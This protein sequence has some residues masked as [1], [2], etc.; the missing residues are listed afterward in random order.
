MRPMKRIPDTLR[1]SA[2]LTLRAA[3]TDTKLPSRFT[4]IAYSGELMP[5]FGAVVDLDS[6][7]VPAQMALLSEH[8]RTNIIGLVETT[9]KANNR[10]IVG[11]TLY[12]DMA[13]SA[14]EKIAQLAARGFGFQMSVGLFHYSE[15]YVPQGVTA[16][17]NGRNIPGPVTVLRNGKVRECSI[18]ALG[19][20]PNTNAVFFGAESGREQA[21][22]SL[23]D[24][25]GR[26][27]SQSA[28]E[29]YMRMSARDFLVV[30]TELRR[31]ALRERTNAVRLKSLGGVY[32]WRREQ[33]AA[34]AP[35]QHATA[36]GGGDGRK[37]KESAV[38]LFTRRA[39]EAAEFSEGRPRSA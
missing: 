18:V 1:L 19:A 32:A 28:R 14:A 7:T 21:I 39:K 10:L 24:A 22:I 27:P 23:F 36:G 34:F 17:V 2:P 26:V 29:A 20:D 4:G 11:G 6:T 38:E 33:L 35:K 12:S 15:E 16:R 5:S 25:L 8:E 37:L 13:G 9:S 30:S 31:L 3:P